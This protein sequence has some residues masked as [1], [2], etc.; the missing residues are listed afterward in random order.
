MA[1][2]S[3][4]ITR[5][6][7]ESTIIEVDVEAEEQVEDAALDKLRDCVDAEWRLDDGSWNQSDVYVTGID[8]IP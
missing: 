7:T 3:V 8:P 2:F 5:D 4:I 6:V 1:R